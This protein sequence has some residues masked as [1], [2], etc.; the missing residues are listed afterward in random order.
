MLSMVNANRFIN[1]GAI[2][3]VLVAYAVFILINYTN[4]TRDQ[5]DPEVKV[6]IQNVKNSRSVDALVF[7]GSNAVYSLSAESLSYN[8]GINWYNAS[9][10]GE[11]GSIN[12][13]KNFIRELSARIDRTKVR[14]IVY[15][16]LFAYLPSEVA[17][18]QPD[19]PNARP[20]TRENGEGIKPRGS[21][22]AYIAYHLRQVL[23][24][25]QRN[26]F[27]DLVFESVKCE[28]TKNPV[29]DRKS[30]D[31]SAD[32]FADKAIFLASVF[33]N[34]SIIIVLPSEYY[35]VANFD[36]SIFEQKLRT[37]FYGLLSQKYHFDGVVKI[38]FQPPYSSVTQVCN[39][40]RHANEDGRVWRT[41]NLIASIRARN[42][43]AGWSN[44]ERT[45]YSN[46]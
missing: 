42:L 45:P 43:F 1:I 28:F 44:R 22:L 33:P 32:F 35:G 20:E 17:D 23:R 7:G 4:H 11:L 21:V 8:T 14:Y 27:G 37:K 25:R 39:N 19:V 5:Y 16:S 24:Q 13:Y 15:S 46:N 31:A 10:D 12:E 34:A 36:D 38:I 3:L 29:H 9:L 41:E 40:T 30:A 26:R 18:A 6:H 2:P